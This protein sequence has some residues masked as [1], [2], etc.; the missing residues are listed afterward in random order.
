MSLSTP[1]QPTAASAGSERSKAAGAASA[2]SKSPT[3]RKETAAEVEAR[4]L[5]KLQV[6]YGDTVIDGSEP[7]LPVGFPRNALAC[8]FN[9][10]RSIMT[11]AKR[12]RFDPERIADQTVKICKQ[13][14]PYRADLVVWLEWLKPRRFVATDP[15]SSPALLWALSKSPRSAEW[16]GDPSNIWASAVEAEHDRRK[17]AKLDKATKPSG[18]SGASGHASFDV[19]APTTVSN[20]SRFGGSQVAEAT[21]YPPVTRALHRPKIP[22]GSFKGGASDGNA[23]FEALRDSSD[24]LIIAKAKAFAMNRTELRA[25]LNRTPEVRQCIENIFKQIGLPLPE[26]DS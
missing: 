21:S 15:Y 17:A 13:A 10:A 8:A 3:R 12:K 23:F 2:T 1:N 25:A 22:Y 6:K 19:K 4:K 9:L 18:G 20:G 24:E 5:R 14:A 7:H 26:A 16:D 11:S